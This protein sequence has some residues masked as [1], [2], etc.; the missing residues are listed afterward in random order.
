MLLVDSNVLSETGRPRPSPAVTAWFERQRGEDLRV[1]VLTIGEIVRGIERVGASDA[2]RARAL[3][4]WFGSIRSRFTI[5]PVPVSEDVSI[6]WGKATGLLLVRGIV[7]PDV[8]GL[9]AATAIVHGWTLVTRNVRDV[10]A[11]GVDAL[12]PWTSE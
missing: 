7:V 9:L 11:M 5:A 1:S 8:D 10:A 2:R 4:A 6:Q 3:E 12:D